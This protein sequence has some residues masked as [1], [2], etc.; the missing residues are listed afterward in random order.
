MSRCCPH[1]EE[2]HLQL[3]TCQ[4]VVHYP[5]EDYPCICSGLRGEG[6]CEECGHAREAHGVSRVCRPASGEYCF[7]SG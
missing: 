1:S 5:N 6:V 4:E 2:E 7:C 3:P